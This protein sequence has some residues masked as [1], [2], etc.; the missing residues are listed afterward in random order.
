M[1]RRLWSSIIWL[2]QSKVIRL[3]TRD[4]FTWS[5]DMCV[6]VEG[7]YAIGQDIYICSKT[8]GLFSESSNATEFRLARP[9]CPAC[10]VTWRRLVT[11]AFDMSARCD[12]VAYFYPHQHSTTT[13]QGIWR[14]R[15]RQRPAA[16]IHFTLLLLTQVYHRVSPPCKRRCPAS[17]LSLFHP[18]MFIPP[19]SDITRG[20]NRPHSSYRRI[21]LNLI[22]ICVSEEVGRR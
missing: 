15:R 19:L 17:L 3:W 20:C 22:S 8:C 5:V 1:K 9:S 12:D 13:V 6:C 10:D 16:D 7:W 14:H 18:T 21:R 4:R 11:R 2:P